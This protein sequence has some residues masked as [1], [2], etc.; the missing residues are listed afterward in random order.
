MRR[1]VKCRGTDS[2]SHC[3]AR[4]C[5][6]STSSCEASCP[7][8]RTLRQRLTAARL[9]SKREGEGGSAAITVSASVCTEAEEVPASAGRLCGTDAS[10]WALKPLSCSLNWATSRRQR[11]ASCLRI[12]SCQEKRAR[13]F[14]K[15]AYLAFWSSDLCFSASCTR[16][17]SYFSAFIMA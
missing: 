13:R 14:V 15:R 1:S 7:I 6:E 10:R 9:V 5:A 4:T 8:E 11:S 12:I 16:W 3:R 17:C 2:I